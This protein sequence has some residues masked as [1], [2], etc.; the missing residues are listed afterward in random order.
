MSTSPSSETRVLLCDHCHEEID[1]DPRKVIFVVAR[2]GDVSIPERV[3]MATMGSPQL[4]QV[5]IFDPAAPF[6][7][8]VQRADFLV[9]D[10][11]MAFGSI[12]CI[13]KWLLKW[14][15]VAVALSISGGGRA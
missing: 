12:V 11:E 6:T 1:R 9:S 14:V 4:P 13:K 7:C 3:L 2:K 10:E 8:S 5:P 15:D